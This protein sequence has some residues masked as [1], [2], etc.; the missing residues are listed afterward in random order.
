MV[1]ARALSATETRPAPSAQLRQALF[2]ERNAS[3]LSLASLTC[4]ARTASSSSLATSY[5]ISL[6]WGNIGMFVIGVSP[7]TFS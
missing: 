3:S 5:A 1:K 7:F 2:A 6:W 4:A